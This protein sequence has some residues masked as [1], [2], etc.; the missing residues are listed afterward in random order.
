MEP[1][2]N[3]ERISTPARAPSIES[4]VKVPLA[5]SMITAGIGAAGICGLSLLTGW[6]APVGK[7]IAGGLA[8]L[9]L[10]WMRGR[11]EMRRLMW[12]MEE[13][14]GD[15]DGDG[16]QGQPPPRQPAGR[17]V[18]QPS[19]EQQPRSWFDLDAA[20]QQNDIYHFAQVVWERQQRGENS[21]GQKALRGTPLPSGFDVNDS[22]HKA[23]LDD[24]D[25]AG[26]IRWAGSGWELAARPALVQRAITAE[27]W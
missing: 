13:F 18:I 14:V 19:Q 26:V 6:P 20:Q 12:K 8:I 21:N 16:H 7:S 25:G 27:D 1:A 10:D 17:L 22:I 2:I 4:D 11:G 5:Q 24:L 3:T 15:L 23:I 9:T